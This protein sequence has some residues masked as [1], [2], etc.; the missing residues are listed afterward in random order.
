MLTDEHPRHEADGAALAR[1]AGARDGHAQSQLSSLRGDD[2]Q[3]GYDRRAQGLCRETQTRLEG[4]L[5]GSTRWPA[6]AGM[7][8]P[9]TAA[10]RL[11]APIARWKQRDGTAP[12]SA[13]QE[14]QQG[15]P[16]G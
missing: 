1:R 10:R 14:C 16:D 8:L 3:R 6:A 4:P 9:S 11:L 12:R 15:A 13:I 5:T 2:P 7:S